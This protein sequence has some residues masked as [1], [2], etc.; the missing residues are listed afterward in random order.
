MYRLTHECVQEVCYE[1]LTEGG[2][3]GAIST[4]RKLFS[5][6]QVSNV[7]TFLGRMPLFMSFDCVP[8]INLWGH[9][10]TLLSHRK[11]SHSIG[12]RIK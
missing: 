8:I 12:I 10:T 1:N 4:K 9:H 3:G 5:P 7:K 2:G 6:Y 11:V